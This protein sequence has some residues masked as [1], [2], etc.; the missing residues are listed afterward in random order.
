VLAR[1]GL[2]GLALLAAWLVLSLAVLVVAGLGMRR[3]LAAGEPCLALSLN[4]FAALLI[5]PISWSHHWVWCVPAILTLASLARRHRS[6]LAA[7]VAACGLVV[8]AAAPQWWFPHGAGRE[9]RWAPWE[10][11]AGSSYVLFAAA[12]LV[13]AACGQIRLWRTGGTATI[14][15]EVKGEGIRYAQVHGL[16]R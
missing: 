11:A 3:A 1:A 15:A 6:R 9:L 10:Q 16:P 5:S 14:L 13:L 4:A 12:V 7:A 8:F 2:S